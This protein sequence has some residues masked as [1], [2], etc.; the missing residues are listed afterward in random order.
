[1]LKIDETTVIR[2]KNSLETMADNSIRNITATLLKET[3]TDVKIEP[4]LQPLTGENFNE[5]TANITN[6]ARLDICA[7][8]F[9]TAGQMAFFD[10]RVFNPNAR[11]YAKLEIAKTYEVNEKEKKKSY[12]ERILQVEHG[13]FTPLVMSATGG[14]G[15]ESRKFYARLAESLSQKRNQIYSLTASWLRRKICFALMKSVCI[16][17]RGSRSVFSSS[18]LE[19]SLDA[20]V[21]VSEITSRVP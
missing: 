19:D 15:R 18:R 2:K 6:E 11:R 8:G 3:C 16:C 20:D 4:Q 5:R 1:M 10:V 21:V 7:R 9:W 14:M 17:I 13:S 12:A